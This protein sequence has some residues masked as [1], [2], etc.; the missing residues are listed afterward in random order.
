MTTDH[1][2]SPVDLLKAVDLRADGPVLWG[3]PVP[4]AR[5]GVY[6]VEL[7]EPLA[8]APIEATRVGK[9]IERVPEL[10]LDG[11]RPTFRTLMARLQSFWLPGQTVLFI[12]GTSGTIGGRI[13]ALRKTPLGDR[14]PY[15]GGHW[16]HALRGLERARVWWATTDAPQEYEDAL[17]SAFADGVPA[18]IGAATP[19]PDLVL[20]WAVLRRPTGERRTHG[21]TGALLPEPVAAPAPGT[22]VTELPPGAADGAGSDAPPPPHPEARR[23][24]RPAAERA[25][26]TTRRTAGASSASSAPSRAP[27][28]AAARKTGP[29]AAPA[30]KAP[31]E[32]PLSREGLQR[33]EA[34][35]DQLRSVRRPEAI[36]RVATAREHG[37]LKENAEYHAAR[38]ELGFIV[39]RIHS[40]E[41]RLR[42]VVVV[43]AA[44]SDTAMIGSTVV[45]EVDG[46]TSVYLLVGS[47]D[48]D[49]AAGRISTASPVGR[50]LLGHGPGTEVAVATPSGAVITYRIKEVR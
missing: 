36:R 41:D 18:D 6:L 31:T 21:I 35:L 2:P 47:T 28:A 45:V 22:T 10:R 4:A 39:G 9:W 34:E 12:G 50:A 8:T 20:P 49:P 13:A 42:H 33:L 15:A 30:T 7:P 1:V 46:E 32:V 27:R 5:P 40:L 48:S 37:D 16:L 26:A 25:A 44:D 29:K 43:E 3:R 24:A 19:Q 11:E 23:S 38:E 14:R 17:L